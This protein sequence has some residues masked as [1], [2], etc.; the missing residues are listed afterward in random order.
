MQ[1]LTYRCIFYIISSQVLSSRRLTNHPH[2]SFKKRQSK[3]EGCDDGIGKRLREVFI[4][5]GLSPSI[6]GKT[7]DTRKLD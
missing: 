1:L 2:A 6:S 7:E 4:F 3:K 5:A